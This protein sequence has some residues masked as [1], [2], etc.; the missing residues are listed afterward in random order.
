MAPVTDTHWAGDDRARRRCERMKGKAAG[1]YRQETARLRERADFLDV[2]DYFLRLA[3]E[4]FSAAALSQRVGGPLAGL[5]CLQ[6]PLEIFLALG[7]H[8]VRLCAGS[9]IAQQA[10]AS[11]LPRQ[12]TSGSTCPSSCVP[13]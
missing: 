5:F 10:A 13:C 11:S 6:A 12:P 3:E 4:P 1:E 9:Q 2:Y 7:I 8:P